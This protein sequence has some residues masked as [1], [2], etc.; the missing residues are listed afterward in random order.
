MSKNKPVWKENKAIRDL[1]VSM[2]FGKFRSKTW[3]SRKSHK[4]SRQEFNQK[5]F[6][7]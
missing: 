1:R 2:E 6:Q 4:Q 3:D 5:G 7:E